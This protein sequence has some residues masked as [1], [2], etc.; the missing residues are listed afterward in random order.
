[1]PN[2]FG[3]FSVTSPLSSISHNAQHDLSSNCIR[4][5]FGPTCQTVADCLISKGSSTL[6][7]LIVRIR[8]RCQRDINSERLR[9][10]RSLDPL[11]TGRHPARL[12]L[13]RG[14]EEKGFIV[15]ASIVRAALIVLL[16]HSLVKATPPSKSVD[17]DTNGE[18][19]KYTYSFDYDRAILI[20]RYPRYVEYARDLHEG[21]AAVVE[22]LLVKGRMGIFE[23][24]KAG[25]QNLERAEFSEEFDTG[26]QSFIQQQLS[27]AEKIANALK[28]LF[29]EG[30][31]ERVSPIH[32]EIKETELV[33]E[34]IPICNNTIVNPEFIEPNG[35]VISFDIGLKSLIKQNRFKK[36]FVTGSVWR[37]NVKMFHASVRA[38]YLGHLVSERYNQIQFSGAIVSAALKYAASK[39]FAMKYILSSEEERQQLRYFGISSSHG[40]SRTQQKS[41]RG[42]FKYFSYAFWNGP[43]C[44]PTQ[45]GGN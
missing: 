34:G 17:V 36:I 15:D 12:N 30:Y 26:S 7:Q 28:V 13:A 35:I 10:V 8:Q 39:E 40:I 23:V 6:S 18:E 16:Q 19:I 41:W 3:G 24:I 14:N 27:H 45:S 2:S 37:V 32:L 42:F 20:Q 29:E 25:V 4:D 21:G 22:E 44:L 5:C 11:K 43:I 31:L 33:G 38:I 1:M 9:L